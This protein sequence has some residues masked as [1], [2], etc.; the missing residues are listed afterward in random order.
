MKLR[1]F[2]PRLTHS[3]TPQRMRGMSLLEL[4]VVIVLI[5]TVLA[6]V[7]GK[8]VANKHRAEAKLAETQ[9]KTLAQQ[10]DSYQSDVGSYPD[11]L[12][13]LVTAPGNAAGW[14]GPY[15]KAKDFQD[16]WQHPI[17]YRK[18][19]EGDAPYQLISLGVDGKPGGDGV[20]K[21]ITAP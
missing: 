15:A 3:P 21:D 4:V 8:I 14:L 5:G 19:G 9:L 1:K 12:L 20:D 17:E 16:P 18:P 7:G 6:V 2:N 13:Q 10:I 11:T